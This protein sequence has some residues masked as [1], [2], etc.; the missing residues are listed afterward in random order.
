M[1]QPILRTKVIPPRRRSDLLERP[2]LLDLLQ[3]QMERSLLLVVAPAG[4]GKTSL[5]IDLIH[6]MDQPVCWYSVDTLD[7]NLY[8]F[9]AHFIAAI[10]QTFPAFGPESNAAL[11][12][13]V[14]GQSGYDQFMSILLNE[15]Y[16]CVPEP[17]LFVID[18][19]HVVSEQDEIDGFV[20]QFIQQVDQHCHL[21]LASRRLL[22]LPDLPLMVARAQVGGVG[23]EE[24]AFRRDEIQL[25]L[26]QNF[27]IDLDEDAATEM[28]KAT[29]GWI[30]GLMLSTKLMRPGMSQQSSLVRSAGVNLYDYLAQQVLAQQSPE[31]VDFLLR[32][33][34]L[35]EFNAVRVAVLLD[36]LFPQMQGRWSRLFNMV[37]EQNLFILHLGEIDDEIGGET[38]SWV[39]YHALFQDFLQQKLSNERRDEEEAILRRMAEYFTDAQEW[40]KAHQALDKLGDTSAIAQFVERVGATLV[41]RDETRLLEAW[42]D[43][44]PSSFLEQRPRLLWLRGCVEVLTEQLDASLHSFTKAASMLEDDASHLALADTLTHRSVAYRFLGDYKAAIAD[45]SRSIELLKEID[46]LSPSAPPTPEFLSPGHL[47]T[48][49]AASYKALGLSLYMAGQTEEAMQWLEQALASYERSGEEQKAAVVSVDIATM[50]MNGGRY[51]K[52]ERQ[53]RRAL[54]RWR[55]LHFVMHQAHVLNNL[56]VV[57]HLQGQYEEA[58]AALQESMEQAQKS[59]QFGLLA[60]AQTSLGDLYADWNR[61]QLASHFYAQARNTT[62]KLEQHFLPLYLELAEAH[63]DCI[64]A[65]WASAYSHLD[66]AGRLVVE[67][68]SDY[69]WGLYQLSMGRF[70]LA[71]QQNARALAPL[72]D[73]AGRFRT[74]GLRIELTQTCLLVTVT[75]HRLDATDEMRANLQCL[76]Q[77]TASLESWQPVVSLARHFAE[78]LSEIS[79]KLEH[80]PQEGEILLQR[81]FLHVLAQKIDEAAALYTQPQ[82][83]SELVEQALV[84]VTAGSATAQHNGLSTSELPAITP[85]EP[86]IEPSLLMIRTLGQ[87]EITFQGY[88]VSSSDWQAQS[89]RDLFLCLVAHPEGLTKEEVGEIFW[90]DSSPE[91]LKTRFKNAIYRLRKALHPDAVQYQKSHYRFNYEMD[92]AYDVQ[93]FLESLENARR[94]AELNA[95]KQWYRRAISAYGGDYLPD[96]DAPWVWLERER[97][98]RLYIQIYLE[99]SE[100]YL[101]TDEFAEARH[102]AEQALSQDPCLEEAHR[103]LMRIHAAMG[104]RAEIARQFQECERALNDE[105]DAP[106][107]EQTINLY[108]R[109][110]E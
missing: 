44:I 65:D 66:T 87:V 41:H 23:V 39:R 75:Y 84:S 109:L 35:G 96:V 86:V 91:Q 16:E 56:G 106:P 99:L 2:R 103:L 60:F 1:S 92:H 52:A 22:S 107:S 71:Q 8:R 64:S 97:L 73:A 7:R 34:L 68:V 80:A 85:A 79:Q 50:H 4:Y 53:F 27:E 55:K 29:E 81:N 51:T 95:K 25:L 15:V 3:Q 24:L 47:V 36:P 76:A 93:V 89:A 31:V 12:S 42:L 30:T 78:D 20:S 63:L 110:M 33:S 88:S 46:E 19:Y 82:P 59:S 67:N 6:R 72:E 21:L 17:F 102:F 100:L 40:E 18:D 77:Q 69:E 104:N 38:G 43:N 90:P 49:Q 48:V 70:Y 13:L 32:T 54:A 14:A 62:R 5:L 28:I 108:Q 45:A 105:I 74:G 58:E 57:C 61:V 101:S 9:L 98:H 26:R 37:V 83:E 10:A 94:T 11:Q